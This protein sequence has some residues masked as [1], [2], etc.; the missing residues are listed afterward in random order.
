MQVTVPKAVTAQ[1]IVAASIEYFSSTA[2][3]LQEEDVVLLSSSDEGG[4]SLRRLQSSDGKRMG[5]S[6]KGIANGAG[7]AGSYATH[8][9]DLFGIDADDVFRGHERQR[10]GDW[11]VEHSLRRVTELTEGED[12]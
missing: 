11:D 3:P 10:L 8:I 7:H 6:D 1:S 5:F 12:L 2:L 9:A 4:V